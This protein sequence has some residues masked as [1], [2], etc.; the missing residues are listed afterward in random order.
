MCNGK[1]CACKVKC[2]NCKCQTKPSTTMSEMVQIMRHSAE[3]KQ[4]IN[5]KV[6]EIFTTAM[7]ERR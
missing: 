1:H 5:Q 3:T 6:M 7:Q 2:K 4:E